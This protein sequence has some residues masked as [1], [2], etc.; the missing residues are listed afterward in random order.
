MLLLSIYQL[1]THGWVE[2]LVRTRVTYVDSNARSL[3]SVIFHR[4]PLLTFM[5]V[6]QGINFFFSVALRPN[7]GHGLPILEVS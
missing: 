2:R 7:V 5:P 6:E 1:H 4:P 3:S